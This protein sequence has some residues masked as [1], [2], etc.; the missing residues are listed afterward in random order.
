MEEKP[1]LT[2][3]HVWTDEDGVSRQTRETIRGFE[4]E[5]MG[6]DAAPQWN[7]HL[8][9]SAAHIMYAQLP[10]GWEG[11]WHENPEPQWILPLSGKWFVETMDGTRVEMGP[12]ELSF[13][14]DQHTKKDK[15]GHKGHRSGTVGNTP[16]LLM[17]IQLKESKW[18]GK[19][20]GN[21]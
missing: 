8:M 11:E 19:T 12:G 17:I 16:A 20:P 1:T 4:K 9:D 2:Y 6:G 5:S 13:G 21:F 14:A 18:A 7:R 15:N 3:W 10:V